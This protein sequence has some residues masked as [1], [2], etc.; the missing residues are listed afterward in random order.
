MDE[1]QQKQIEQ[2]KNHRFIVNL[3]SFLFVIMLTVVLTTNLTLA[4]FGASDEAGNGIIFGRVA[5]DD[6]TQNFTIKDSYDQILNKVSPG[7][8]AK[9]N[10]SVKNSGTADVLLRFRVVLEDKALQNKLDTSIFNISIQSVTNTKFETSPEYVLYNFSTNQIVA[11]GVANSQNNIW[12]VRRLALVGNLNTLT[13]DPPDEFVVNVH[14]SGEEMTD[15]YKNA[16]IGLY[17]YVET[18]QAANNG[19]QR[20]I[21]LPNYN[22]I[23]N[24]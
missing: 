24:E 12:Y 19:S 21:T 2:L 1:M 10:F 9:I 7:A 16:Q 14:F 18:V 6:I 23:W 11:G 13:N 8:D 3:V 4:A 15:N 5:L 22:A 20:D 17:V